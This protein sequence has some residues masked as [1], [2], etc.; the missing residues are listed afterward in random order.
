M[1]SL[2][3]LKSST[4]NDTLPEMQILEMF[5]KG[6]RNYLILTTSMLAASLVISLVFFQVFHTS[7][8]RRTLFFPLAVSPELKG[9]SR[10][11]PRTGNTEKDVEN[12]IKEMILGPVDIRLGRLV[13]RHTRLKAGLVRD[14]TVYLDF[15][16]ELAVNTDDLRL[17]TDELIE[18]IVYTVR[19]NFR[20]IREVVVTI[21]GKKPFTPFFEIPAP[22]L[23]VPG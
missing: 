23:G 2:I 13:D 22:E 18:I 4:I 11:V 9:E 12:L 1:V 17:S 16:H 8:I 15:S 7:M 6:P 5:R 14:N 21:E 19:R 20:T 3:S 10:R